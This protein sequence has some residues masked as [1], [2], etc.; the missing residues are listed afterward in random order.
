VVW[1]DEFQAATVDTTK[2]TVRNGT[3]SNNEASCLFASQVTQATGVLSLRV[4]K[5]SYT[6]GS[7]SSQ[8][9]SG[10]VDSINKTPPL[11]VGDRIEFR[12][13]MPI[14]PGASQ[15]YWPALWLTSNEADST[16]TAG[17]IDTV[18]VWGAVKP[19]IPDSDYVSVHS[20]YEDMNGGAGKS[21][22]VNRWP[23]G[24]PG[25]GFHTY[26]TRLLA[27]RVEF[28][29]DGTIVRTV[30]TTTAPWLTKLLAAGVTWNIRMNVQ[31]CTAST[32]CSAPNA[33]TVFGQTMDI[34]YVRV[35]R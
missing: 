30:T 5:G 6:C 23:T 7:R 2:W 31:V 27:D 26:S 18:E 16:Y 10:Y 32:W 28:A 4:D 25:D 12:A 11:R 13:R 29:V 35:Y 15:G 8:F 1:G 33:A 19:D 3:Y 14:I 21:S 22:Y 20:V 17:E 34:D 9:A 24:H